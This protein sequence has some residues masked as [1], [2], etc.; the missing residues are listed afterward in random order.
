M[1]ENVSFHLLKKKK[2]KKISPFA[3]KP[4]KWPNL[5]NVRTTYDKLK[6]MFLFLINVHYYKA[7]KPLKVEGY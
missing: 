2:D 1:T 6:K 7:Q 3:L 5:L 4:H